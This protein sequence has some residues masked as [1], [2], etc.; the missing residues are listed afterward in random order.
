VTPTD[1]TLAPAR[2]VIEAVRPCVDDGQ[3]DAKGSLG[4]PVEVSA[5]AFLD[6][7]DMLAVEVRYRH[8][9]K[10]AWKTEQM[11]P[12]GNDRWE[13]QFSPTE[14]GRFQFQIRAFADHFATWLHDIRARSAAG[15][16]LSVELLAGAQLADAAA[17]NA[18]GAD[19]NRLTGLADDIRNGSLPDPD[20]LNDVL[21]AGLV[22]RYTDNVPSTTSPTYGVRIERPR[23]RFS[24]WY[25]LFPRSTSGSTKTHGTFMDV[26][27]RLDYVRDIGADV[28][29][30]PPIHP[31]GTT[32]RKGRNGATTAR[33]DD[34]GSPWAIGSPDGGHTAIHPDLGTIDDFHKLIGAASDRGLEIALD[35]AYQCSPDHPWVTT[36]PEWFKHRPDGSIRYAE[37]PPKKY[38]DIYPIDFESSDWR[39]LWDALRDV[40][41][42]WIAQGVT[43]FRVDNPHTK[44]F[45]FWEWLIPD[46]QSRHPDTIFLAEAFTRPKIMKRLAKV[47]FTQSYTYFAWRTQKWEI[48]Q[49]LTELTQTDVVDYFRPNFWPNTPDILT[50]QL[51]HGDRAM[52]MVRALLAGTLAANYGIYGPVFELCERRPRHEG[53]EEYLDGEK[54]EIRHYDLDNPESIAPF[55]KRLNAIRN[56]QDALQHDRTLEFHWADSDQ[57]IAYSKTA[58]GGTTGDPASAPILVIANLDTKHQQSGWVHL[59]PD[60]LGLSPGAPFVVHDLLTDARYTWHGEH[61]FVQLDPTIAPAHVFRIEP[62][63][64]TA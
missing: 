19:R 15:Q 57:L 56:S 4:A 7:H 60:I 2:P 61:N 5:D 21:L 45:A 47:G 58:P 48:E 53:S 16:D 62:A 18:K 24:T 44:A 52:F 29:Y 32:A 63:S 35:L 50:E 39:A 30:L 13:A 43:I 12:A 34:V 51:Q 9:S 49:Y 27:D 11:R 41:E 17:G 28:V 10:R 6:G 25:E 37:N 54:Y 1:N 59:R 64:D 46:I 14:P 31:I 38:E 3:Y 55:L 8:E 22:Q 20:E 23:A 40:V 42:H 26:V 33:P 36:H